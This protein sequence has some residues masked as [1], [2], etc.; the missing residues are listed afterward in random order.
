MSLSDE[1]RKLDEELTKFFNL[2]LVSM[3]IPQVTQAESS[4][5]DQGIVVDDDLNSQRNR[6]PLSRELTTLRALASQN[7]KMSETVARDLQ[8]AEEMKA[9]IE[10]RGQQLF[11]EL[12]SF[13]SETQASN[14]RMKILKNQQR[15]L[16]IESQSLAGL[17]HPIR[18][19]PIDILR[20]VFEW[21]VLIGTTKWCKTA[22]TL[23]QVCRRWRTIAHETPDL[24][25]QVS[26]TETHCNYN[27]AALWGHIVSRI[28]Q[29]SP[30][31]TLSAWT[32]PLLNDNGSVDSS[33]PEDP[34]S[35]MVD[36]IEFGSV[37]VALLRLELTPALIPQ[38]MGLGESLDVELDRIEVSVG[39]GPNNAN[40]LDVICFLQHQ[41]PEA[42]EARITGSIQ[43]DARSASKVENLSTLELVEIR[44]SSLL[45]KLSSF[46]SLKTLELSSVDLRTDA[47]NQVIVLAVL[48]VLRVDG[49]EKV[50]WQYVQAPQLLEFLAFGVQHIHNDVLSF[51]ERHPTIRRVLASISEDQ[52]PTFVLAAP[53]LEALEIASHFAGID[54]W[55]A[56]G[57]NAPPFLNLRSLVVVAYDLPDMEYLENLVISRGPASASTLVSIYH[58]PALETISLRILKE[59]LK[60]CDWKECASLARSSITHKY[61][62]GWGSEW[63]DCVFSWNGE[64]PT[65]NE[66]VD[67]VFSVSLFD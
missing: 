52:F 32:S 56:A 65:R 40:S 2:P 38:L 21:A 1:L 28:R 61:V 64:G 29:V 27:I 20:I 51:L 25:A 23:S 14:R 17:L 33:E 4:N 50:P 12:E 31:I 26:I 15:A 43:I 48:Q 7:T 11:L 30:K 35:L 22:F 67:H 5:Q 8:V 24:W 55:D 6:I 49:F 13:R 10:Q 37:R 58:I 42:L 39:T 41:F 36:A 16:Q 9:E 3:N 46:T 66:V 59:D 60:S 45:S 53:N 47:L 62:S 18:R 63:V 44:S 54:M 57:L 34:F 19:Y